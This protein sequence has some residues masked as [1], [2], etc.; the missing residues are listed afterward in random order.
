MSEDL[1]A[2]LTQAIE[3]AR[4]ER[5]AQPDLVPCTCGA[6]LVRPYPNDT[7]MTHSVVECVPARSGPAMTALA[8]TLA[9]IAAFCFTAWQVMEHAYLA[10]RK[11]H[12]QTRGALRIA[13]A[14]MLDA[15]EVLVDAA[16]TPIHD[17]LMDSFG[18]GRSS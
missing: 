17:A 7:G 1:L 18:E 12:V 4:A 10:E 16:A 13:Y 6:Q 14:A 15:Q 11:A 2:A 8:I 5:R 3:R 9:I